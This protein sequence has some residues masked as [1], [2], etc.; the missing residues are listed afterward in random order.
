MITVYWCD[1]L[2]ECVSPMLRPG[3]LRKALSVMEVHPTDTILPV[4]QCPAWREYYKNTFVVDAPFDLTIQSDGDGGYTYDS[5][6]PLQNSRAHMVHVDGAHTVQLRIQDLVFADAPLMAEQLQPTLI[7]NTFHKKIDMVSG[8]FNIGKWLR[9][10]NFAFQTFV[11]EPTTIEIKRGDPLYFLR[12]D[13][14]EDIEIKKFKPSPRIYELLNQ[15]GYVKDARTGAAKALE[16]Y[17]KL[18][19]GRNTQKDALSEIRKNLL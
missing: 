7:G 5:S 16:M 15:C 3:T 18:F 9:P 12:F 6:I 4:T 2:S 13:T 17:Y 11:G 10:L 1:E 8:A 14:T 19:L